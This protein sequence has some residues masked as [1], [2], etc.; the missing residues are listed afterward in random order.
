[1]FHRIR[2]GSLRHAGRAVLLLLG[3]CLAMLGARE[4]WSAPASPAG[5]FRIIV[6]PENTATTLSRE[7][8]ADAFLRNVQDWESGRRIAPVD[9][10]PSSPTRQEFSKHILLRSV[11][12]VRNYW[13]QRIFAGRGIPPPELESDAAIVRYVIANR[14][15]VGYVS[16]AAELGSAQVVSV[17]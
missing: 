13:Q 12:A 8:L 14:N 11:A 3:T 4:G 10:L 2:T 9:Q 6:N 5:G 7:F 17:R 15:A 1:M 16:S